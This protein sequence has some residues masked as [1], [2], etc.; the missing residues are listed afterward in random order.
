MQLTPAQLQLMQRMVAGRNQ[1]LR[2]SFH[3]AANALLRKGLAFVHNGR[4]YVSPHGKR[5]L[6]ALRQEATT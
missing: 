5:T 6:Q 2:V 4:L 1:G 3:A